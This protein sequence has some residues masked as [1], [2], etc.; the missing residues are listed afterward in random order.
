MFGWIKRLVGKG[1]QAPPAAPIGPIDEWAWSGSAWVWTG[2]GAAPPPPPPPITQADMH[3]G[4]ADTALAAGIPPSVPAG[5]LPPGNEEFRRKR[6]A[7]AMEKDAAAK[8]MRG[9]PGR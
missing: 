6:V 2:T 5:L 9:A 4:R 8:Y 1:E 7:E 3:G